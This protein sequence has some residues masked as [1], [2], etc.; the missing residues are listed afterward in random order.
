MQPTETLSI[1]TIP[2]RAPASFRI[3]A[4]RGSSAYA[5]E[6]TRPAFELAKAMGVKEVELDAQ[7]S[8]DG[9]VVLCHDNTLVRYGHGDRFVEQ[10][11][12]DALLSLDMGSWFSPHQFAGVP[13]MTFGRVIG[14]FCRR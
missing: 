3:I 9:V 4:H 11:S 2:M 14:R 6:N 12:A 8:A 1:E 10:M 13:M 7:L 5:P